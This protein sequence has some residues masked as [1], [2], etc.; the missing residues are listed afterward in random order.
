[1]GKLD[2]PAS[3]QPAAERPAREDG[4]PLETWIISAVAR[5]VE[6]VETAAE[7]SASARPGARLIG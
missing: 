2:L 4:V 1:M 3:L 5:K 6:A 7:F